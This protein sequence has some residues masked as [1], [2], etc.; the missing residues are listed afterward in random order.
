MRYTLWE[1]VYFT[2]RL[3]FFAAIE[4]PR[5]VCMRERLVGVVVQVEGNEYT[6]CYRAEDGEKIT[7][8]YGSEQFGKIKPAVGDHLEMVVK[9]NLRKRKDMVR[10]TLPLSRAERKILDDRSERFE[11]GEINV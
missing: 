3:L 1:K 5:R 6:V 10:Q 7:H 4:G 11:T 2:A 8:V 9:V